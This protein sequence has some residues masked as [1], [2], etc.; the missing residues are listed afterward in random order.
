MAARRFLAPVFLIAFLAVQA[1]SQITIATAASVQFAM[2]AL[3]TAFTKSTGIEAKAVYGAS[4]ALVTQIRNGAPFDVFVSADMGFPD[5]LRAK[6]YAAE[7]PRPY[8]FGKLVLW[9]LKDPKD[10][11]LSPDLAFL[12]DPGVSK[13]ALADIKKAPYG[14]EAAKALKKA[15]VYDAVESKL[16]FGENISQVSQYV[17]TG[18]VEVGFDAKSIVV[19]KEMQGKGQWVEVDPALYDRIAQGAVMTRTGYENHAREAATFLEFLY[20]KTGK[21]IL[22]DYGYAVP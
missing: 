8:A 6:G 16:V 12:K 10:L 17:L 14:R 22:E 2:E 3:R 4:G 1:F 18:N 20:S 21:K 15:G 11:K 7:K 5:S 9:T 19:A 13:I